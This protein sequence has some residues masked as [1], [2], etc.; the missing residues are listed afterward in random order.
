M[1][2]ID[3]T[4]RRVPVESAATKEEIVAAYDALTRP[5]LIRLERYAKWRIRGLGARNLGRYWEDLLREAITAT[6]E[7]VRR[8]NKDSVDFPR[9]LIG[10]MRSI[11]SRWAKEF[12]PDEAMLESDTIRVSP[13]GIISN[14]VLDAQSQE[15]NAQDS[16]EQQ[17]EVEKIEQLVGGKPLAW[18]ILEG[19]RDGM[20]GP[21]IR[22]TLEIS[23]K[24]YE[25][26]MKWL[27]RNL[28]AVAN[29]G[30][31]I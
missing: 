6:Y 24:D 14:P 2:P 29:K 9:H 17:E 16:L 26:A 10:A 23:Q 27:R 18:L 13:E 20:T 1:K 4:S 25:T 22:E 15:P 28:E 31:G 8:W 12:D 21:Q 3:K 19:R 30:R 11:S 7:D 5:E